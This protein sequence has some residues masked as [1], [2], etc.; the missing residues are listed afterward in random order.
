L[1]VG[2]DDYP[3]PLPKLRGC[4]ND[5]REMRQ[6]LDARVDP[7]GRPLKEALKI[8]FLANQ[9]ATRESVIHAF[10]DHLG[11]AGSED[12]A[13]FSYSGH[14]S[15]E[16]A[17]D[18][19]WKIEPDHL[20][21]TLVL[22][23]SRSEGSWDLADKELSKLITEVSSGGAHV[24][25]LL[26]CCHSGS[27][28]RAPDF[29]ETAVRRAPTDLRPRPLDSFIF[30][31]D[32]LPQVGPSREIGTS[33]SGWEATGRHVLLA[34]C[35]DDEEAKEYQGG[36]A[37]RGAF[38]YFLVETL[39]AA[40]GALTYRDLFA[41]TAGLVQG[42]VQRQSPQL[43]ASFSEDLSRPFLGG[44]IRQSPRTFVASYR[45]GH[46]SIDAG[47]MHGI[48]NSVSDD[49]TEVA[50][51]AFDTS[52]DD[53]KNPAKALG[54]ARVAR[55]LGTTSELEIINGAVDPTLMNPLI[56]R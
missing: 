3:P 19:F 47:R 48:S 51:F 10:R 40:R 11:Q 14:G 41:R 6:Y 2:I 12:V 46:W 35:R 9:E 37:T 55:V 17:P 23:N 31:L 29:A 45:S 54:K 43:E 4:V 25:V 22:Y 5:L 50:L 1:L 44:A 32:E 24:L 26:D 16:Q 21:E 18:Q 52:D 34:A 15:Q 20:D 33:S 36:G 7:G 49:A 53:L 38:S 56:F 39:R 30:T 27:G 13:V 42:Q 8:K 28:T